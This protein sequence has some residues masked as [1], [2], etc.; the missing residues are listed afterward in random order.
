MQGTATAS[1]V[2]EPRDVVGIV[3]E[4]VLLGLDKTG[5][6]LLQALEATSTRCSA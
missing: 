3:E 4:A 2:R 1:I 5:V 6:V